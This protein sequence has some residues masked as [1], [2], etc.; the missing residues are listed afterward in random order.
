MAESG[1]KEIKG[2]EDLKALFRAL[3]N[4][5]NSEYEVLNQLQ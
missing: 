2:E 5:E 3:F 1:R 4:F